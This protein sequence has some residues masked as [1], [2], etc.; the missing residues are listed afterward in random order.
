MME[1]EKHLV[2]FFSVIGQ[3]SHVIKFKLCL[4]VAVRK[5]SRNR[6]RVSSVHLEAMLTQRRIM[7]ANRERKRDMK[8]FIF[9][10]SLS[11]L[12]CSPVF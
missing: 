7:I 5:K 1:L 8:S 9:F 10:L 12:P 2:R 6:N 4:T 3:I 11:L